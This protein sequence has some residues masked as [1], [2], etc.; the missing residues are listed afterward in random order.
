[1]SAQACQMGVDFLLTLRQRLNRDAETMLSRTRPPNSMNWTTSGARSA[2]NRS[3]RVQPVDCPSSSCGFLCQWKEWNTSQ[4]NALRLHAQCFYLCFLT[5]CLLLQ[6]QLTIRHF[7]DVCHFFPIPKECL[8][9]CLE[10]QMHALEVSS[11]SESLDLQEFYSEHSVSTG[12]IRLQRVYTLTAAGT[13][14]I[15]DACSAF[16]T[17]T[18]CSFS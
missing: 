10:T 18:R 12:Y 11:Q 7:A 17:S 6:W 2:P 4:E 1:M 5:Q 3:H 9:L 16:Y 13:F 8:T 15:R 14:S